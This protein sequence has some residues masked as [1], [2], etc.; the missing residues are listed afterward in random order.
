M[1]DRLSEFGYTFQIKI[2]TCLIKNKQFLQQIND[3][4]K[5]SYFEN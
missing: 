1:K 4:L 5:D 3:I 2:I